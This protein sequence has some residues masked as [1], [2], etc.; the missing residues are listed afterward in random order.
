MLKHAPGTAAKPHSLCD[1]SGKRGSVLIETAIILPIL[2]LLFA[3]SI[4]LSMLF[5]TRQS[6][7]K[8]SS[9]SADMIA[10]S[11]ITLRESDFNEVFEA[12]EFISESVNIRENGRV[13]ISGFIGTDD[14]PETN[15]IAWQRC[16]GMFDRQSMLGAEGDANLALPGGISLRTNEMVIISEVSLRYSPLIFETFFND[17]LL[18]SRSAFRPRFGALATVVSDAAIAGCQS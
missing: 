14:G 7:S 8:L 9:Q 3:G 16:W 15:V 2:I 18:T 10:Q 17:I 11:D 13:V 12:I 5:L 4:E 6:M 1:L